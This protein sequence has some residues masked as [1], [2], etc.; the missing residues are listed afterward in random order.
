MYVASDYYTNHLV[1]ANSSELGAPHAVREAIAVPLARTFVP[2]TSRVL[3]VRGANPS[4]AARAPAKP[5]LHAPITSQLGTFAESQ[6]TGTIAA[7][8]NNLRTT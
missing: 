4:I 3:A 8:A 1:F 7:E 5:R 6:E 2:G